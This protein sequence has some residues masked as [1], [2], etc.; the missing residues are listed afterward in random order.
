MCLVAA[1]ED[2]FGPGGAR[3]GWSL[4]LEGTAGL[5]R[6]WS[7]LDEVMVAAEKRIGGARG[8]CSRTLADGAE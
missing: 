2:E 5:P 8:G 1:E 4:V 3:G 7:M 6:S